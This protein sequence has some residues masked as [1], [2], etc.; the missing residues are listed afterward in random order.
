ML[1]K[2]LVTQLFA[3]L[4]VFCRIGSG[5][6]FMPGYSEG[7][8]LLRYRLL[9]A[10]ALSLVITPVVAPLLPK[11]P[12]DPLTLAILLFGEIT[13]GVF[14]GLFCRIIIGTMHITGQIISFNAGLTTA[15]M[16]DINQATQGTLIGTLFSLTAVVIIFASNLHHLM[17][18]GLFDSYH[19]FPAGVVPQWEDM[20]NVTAAAASKSF[21]MAVR[22]SAPFSIVALVVYL[23]G[24]ILSRVMPT[25]QV[26]FVIQAPQIMLSLFL[27]MITFSAILFTY[28]EYFSDTLS[29]FFSP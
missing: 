14:I 18:Q 29:H 11:I 9:L 6:A 19:L 8:V 1:E 22:L 3:F 4:L 26:F 16:F 21:M 17:L 13:I 5:L 10:M 7:Y 23:G 28:L 12:S 15:Q 20:A 25:M 2:L 27:M 24:G